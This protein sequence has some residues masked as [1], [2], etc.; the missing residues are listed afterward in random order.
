MVE[1]DPG[2][3]ADPEKQSAATVEQAEVDPT[4]PGTAESETA[5]SK[6]AGSEVAGSGT[7]GSGRAGS[8]QVGSGQAGSGSAG[9]DEPESVGAEPEKTEAEKQAE[10]E[11]TSRRTVARFLWSCAWLTVLVA[12]FL[13]SGVL[14]VGGDFGAAA[15]LGTVVVYLCMAAL[16]AA[17]VGCALR[18]ITLRTR[19]LGPV[20]VFQVSTVIVAVAVICGLAI[21]TDNKSAIALLFPWALTYWMYGLDRAKKPETPAS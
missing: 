10:A 12:V 21:P 5:G 11:E 9:A 8:G 18:R 4:G 7:A 15:W 6:V 17:Y 1:S 3:A 16:V 2:Q 14:Q 20:D 19:L 13:F